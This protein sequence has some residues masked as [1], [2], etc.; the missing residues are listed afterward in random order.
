MRILLVSHAW[1]FPHAGGAEVAAMNLA[2]ALRAEGHQVQLLACVPNLDEATGYDAASDIVLVRSATQPRSYIWTDPGMA[3]VWHRLIAAFSPDIVHLH[4]YVNVGAELALVAKRAAPRAKVVLTLHEYLAIC[5]QDG[6][7]LTSSGQLC[8]AAAVRKCASCIGSTPA[9]IANHTS[10]LLALFQH[11]DHFVAPSH[12]LLDRYV[13]W[14]VPV[15]RIGYVPNIVAS[16]APPDSVRATASPTRFVFMSQHTPYKGLDVL[17]EAL[18]YIEER[19]PDK[20]EQALVDIWG[21]GIERFGTAWTERIDALKNALGLWVSFRGAYQPTQTG[22][23]YSTADWT[24]VPSVW[25]ENRPLVIEE[26]LANRVP[27]LA[28]GIGG[29]AELI[30]TPQ[31]GRTFTAGDPVAL[32]AAIVEVIGE[33]RPSV[34]YVASTEAVEHVRLYRSLLHTSDVAP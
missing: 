1:P 28:S 25:W 2:A 22:Q 14:G 33:P 13:A 20:A 23:I 9:S 11:V 3:R 21:S 17:L 19:H 31:R 30:C 5:P 12:F 16:Q 10:T 18:R 32:A 7:M 27:V 8:S 26:S 29:M 15:G 4:H 24:I 34:D 6:Q